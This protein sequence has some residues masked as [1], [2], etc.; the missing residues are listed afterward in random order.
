[1]STGVP[2]VN[3]GGYSEWTRGEMCTGVL[4]RQCW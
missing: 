1:M 3:A 4:K 2:N